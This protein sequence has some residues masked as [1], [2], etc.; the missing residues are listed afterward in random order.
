VTS[1]VE[2][3]TETL[4]SELE[5]AAAARLFF[6]H[7][8]VGQ[9]LLDGVRELSAHHR[10]ALTV[11]PAA[12]ARAGA[13][14]AWLETSGGRNKDP[15]SK[16][17][18]FVEKVTAG[19]DAESELAFLKL[20]YVDFNPVTD[21]DGLFAYYDQAISALKRRRPDLKIGHVTVPLTVE[22]RDLKSRLRRVLGRQVWEDVANVRRYEFNRRLRERFAA[23]PIFDLARAEATQ[24]DGTRQTFQ[25][26]GR[27]YD[28]LVPS[29]TDDGGHLNGLGQRLLGIQM[30]RFVAAALQRPAAGASP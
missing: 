25:L 18:D 6:A 12:P 24:P 14:P 8:S 22:P 15:R 21:V 27:A 3:R 9:N 26:G 20:C 4:Q 5:A 13:G 1:A 7:H 11:A 29:Y 30:V 10:V 17:D 28:S 23:D 19:A 2:T 16:I